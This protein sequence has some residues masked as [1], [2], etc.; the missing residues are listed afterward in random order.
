MTLLEYSESL[1][2]MV[3]FCLYSVSDKELKVNV[4]KEEEAHKL[5]ADL[6]NIIFN[7]KQ[8]SF[9]RIGDFEVMKYSSLIYFYIDGGYC[10]MTLN[11]AE[12]ILSKLNQLFPQ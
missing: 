10:L 11:D 4:Y 1:E 12:K 6:S 5:S 9:G 7:R 2:P 3:G 8:N